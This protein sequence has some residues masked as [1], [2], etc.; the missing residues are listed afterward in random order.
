MVLVETKNFFMSDCKVGNRKSEY[1]S[2]TVKKLVKS[3]TFGEI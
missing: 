2:H 3:L 1:G